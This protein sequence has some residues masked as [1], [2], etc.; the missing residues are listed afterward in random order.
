MRQI[1]KKLVTDEEDRPVAVLIEYED[2]KEIERLL[3]SFE[4]RPLPAPTRDDFDA[5][6]EAAEGI[7]KGGDGLEYQRRIRDEWERR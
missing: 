2:W 1:R 6:L 3:S 5:A 4:G 7:W